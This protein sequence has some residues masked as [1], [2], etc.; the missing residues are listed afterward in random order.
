MPSTTAT[1]TRE[2]THKRYSVTVLCEHVQ[3]QVN[4]D[5]IGCEARETAQAE[6]SENQHFHVSIVDVP[7]ASMVAFCSERTGL[8][9]GV[10]AEADV[11][12]L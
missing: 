11:I 4:L 7:P 12:V 10:K 3:S 5:E 1:H 2:W 8:A 9:L 6:G